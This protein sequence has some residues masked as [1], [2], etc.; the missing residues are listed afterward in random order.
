MY[1]IRK[2]KRLLTAEA[3]ENCLSGGTDCSGEGFR[4]L[5]FRCR[6][7]RFQER[8]PPGSQIGR[9]RVRAVKLGA[10][11]YIAVCIRDCR[12]GAGRVTRIQGCGAR[13][14]DGGMLRLQH[15]GGIIRVDLPSLEDVEAMTW[16]RLVGRANQREGPVSL[17][18]WTAQS[19]EATIERLG[20]EVGGAEPDPPHMYGGIR[21]SW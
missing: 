8:P 13:K 15:P 12:S 21:F 9:R 6:E 20:V 11:A 14:F 17:N 18:Q 1:D 16:E 4:P 7:W 10:G 3:D 2:K 19:S 5:G